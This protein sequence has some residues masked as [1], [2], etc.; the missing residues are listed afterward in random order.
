MKSP[1]VKDNIGST[2][3]EEVAETEENFQ[4][5]PLERL[6]TAFQ[7]PFTNM[8]QQLQPIGLR[9]VAYP[10]G[11]GLTLNFA[12]N[13][14]RHIR[15][16]VVPTLAE[17]RH[18]PQNRNNGTQVLEYSV[19]G[20]LR[21]FEGRIVRS[22]GDKMLSIVRDITE[23]RR[24]EQAITFQAGLLNTIDHEV[25]ATDLNGEGCYWN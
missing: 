18:R 15:L 3:L 8:S 23:R 22:D 6:P 10:N 25:I 21:W 11:A 19:Q 20:Q 16:G 14:P 4:Y 12:C 7:G 24:S 2:A 17:S 13:H 9:S 5:E 1:Y